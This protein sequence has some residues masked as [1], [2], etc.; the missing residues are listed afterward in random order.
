[1]L[2]L[3]NGKWEFIRMKKNY[4]VNKKNWFY[5]IFFCYLVLIRGMF[6]REGVYNC[7]LKFDL[8]FLVSIE[9]SRFVEYV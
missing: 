9:N 3:V 6:S 7:F 5:Y 1:M 4:I 8:K 2:K